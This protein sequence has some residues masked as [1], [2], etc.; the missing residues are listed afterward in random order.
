MHKNQVRSMKNNNKINNL[1][2]NRTN[3]IRK[4]Q[5]ALFTISLW[6][7]GAICLFSCHSDQLHDH[8][9]EEGHAHE[10][11]AGEEHH[12][13]DEIV[14]EHDKAEAAGVVVER[15]E[16][17]KFHGVI[18]TSGCVMAASC[19]ETT[20]V[21][22]VSGRVGQTGHISEGMYVNSGT[23][24]YT[25]NSADMQALE[26]DPIQHARI[27]F[28]QAKR[29]FERAETLVQDQIISEKDFLLAKAEYEAAKLTYEAICRNRSESGV[30]VKAPRSGYVKQNL[31]KEGDYVDAGQPLMVITQNQ[32]LY[33]RAEVPERHWNELNRISC[34]KF[35]T[36]YS[37][38]LYDI[39]DMGGHV[40]SYARSSEAGS[41]YIPFIFEFNNTGD[42]LQ[43]SY[44]EI[45]LITGE[46]DNVITI[47][48]TAVTEEQGIHYIYIKV[49]EDG[50]RKQQVSLGMNDGDR[51][52]IVE[53]LKGGEEVV[54]Q[55]ATQ[56]RLASATNAIPAH[57]HNH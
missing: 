19:D 9:E 30:V 20:V 22:T 17:G 54:V 12:H 24:L 56:V 45:F 33:L 34:A 46:L 18:H 36:S 51:I 1:F 23:N 42:V 48:L 32:H 21:A 53:G 3:R 4:K 29:E 14:L 27:T 2:A 7:T 16:K 49:D 11:A 38:Q 43:G 26:G 35:R 40:Q 8:D 25:L 13:S 44:A 47:P 55:G 6:L 57:T 41:A 31:V 52:E 28:E 15:I 5:I 10:A 50:Y 37:D 39:T